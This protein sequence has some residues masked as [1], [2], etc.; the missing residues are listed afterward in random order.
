VV[1]KQRE[2][3]GKANTIG[4]PPPACHELLV[5]PGQSEASRHAVGIE[6]DAEK[7]LAFLVGQ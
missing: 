3:N 4:I 7:S 1:A 2:L 6:R 5:G